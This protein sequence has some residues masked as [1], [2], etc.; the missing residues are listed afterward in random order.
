MIFAQS[1]GELGLQ[2]YEPMR[3]ECHLESVA[4]IL[5]IVIPSIMYVL[6]AMNSV[7][8]LLKKD[9]VLL[10]N[11]NFEQGDGDYVHSGK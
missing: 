11:G 10:L 7:N 2:D 3:I 8:K 5:G 4:A 9:T 6:A 1:F